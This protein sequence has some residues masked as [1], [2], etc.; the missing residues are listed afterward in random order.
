M[1]VDTTGDESAAALPT[2]AEAHQL[3]RAMSDDRASRRRWSSLMPDGPSSDEDFG[4]VTEEWREAHRAR[5]VAGATDVPPESVSW[6]DLDIL[7]EVDAEAG[8]ALWGRMRQAAR[9]ELDSGWRAA[10]AITGRVDDEAWDRVRFLGVRDALREEWQPR[11]GVESSLVDMLAQI[12]TTFEIWMLR[13]I[14]RIGVTG[15]VTTREETARAEMDG[16][17]VTLRVS[18]KEELDQSAAMADRWQ[19]A[20]LRT[21]RAL[22]DLRRHAPVVIQS[23]G[24]VNIGGQQINLS[25]RE[26]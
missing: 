19:R 15:R 11:V 17:Y 4:I 12:Q 13:H 9:E 26:G 2:V 21:V 8:E 5:L 24:Q 3:G 14:E 18:D 1:M 25:G 16:V 23:A 7:T 6:G 20:Y 10:R 22:R